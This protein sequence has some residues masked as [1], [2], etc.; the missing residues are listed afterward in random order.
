MTCH[1]CRTRAYLSSDDSFRY[2]LPSSEDLKE[3]LFFIPYM[4]LKGLIFLLRRSG[5]AHR[6]TDTTLLS[7]N[8]KGLPLS[9][10]L[11]PQT[12]KLRFATPWT[13]GRFLKY[14]RT[15]KD[16]LPAIMTQSG[17]HPA[18][19][20]F[21]GETISMIYQPAY[22]RQGLLHDAVLKRPLPGTSGMEPSFRD[23]AQEDSLPLISFMTTLCPSCGWDLEG[24]KDTLVLVCRNCRSMWQ[25]QGT[26]LEQIPYAFLKEGPE[27]LHYLP[28]WKMKVRIEGMELSSMADLIRFANL[29]RVSTRELERTPLF[30][31][32]PAFKIQPAQ[33]LRWGRQLTVAQPAGETTD[34]LPEG[35]LYPVT[36]PVTEALE[37]I[38]ITLFH[39]AANKMKTLALL[40]GVSVYPE[41]TLLVYHPFEPNRRELTHCRLGLTIDRTAMLFGVSL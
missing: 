28:F 22:F 9:L 41:E 26:V 8:Q 14:D 24:E 37:G 12:M 1:Y 25:C 17:E 13:P 11:R 38:R 32:S 27:P 4:R 21:I 23:T 29:P 40:P 36:L 2:I 19:Q 16:L 30:F 39:L 10:G 6:F 7:L 35:T 20:A 18:P 34:L 5:V 31:W 3:D 15:I 33:F